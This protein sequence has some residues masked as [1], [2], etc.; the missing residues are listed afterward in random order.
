[1]RKSIAEY[2]DRLEGDEKGNIEQAIAAVEEALK[3]ED[4]ERIDSA[5]NALMA[6][7]QKLG[8]RMYA[9]Q[10]QQ[11]AG[12][13]APEGEASGGARSTAQADDVVD[14]EFKEVKRDA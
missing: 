6:A 4:K 7:S 8:E 11:A 3:T 9:G 13:G 14:A 2:G 10:Q 5:S 1:V 12:A